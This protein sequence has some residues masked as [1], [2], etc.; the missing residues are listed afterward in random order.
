MP[1]EVAGTVPSGSVPALAGQTITAQT[2]YPF[3]GVIAVSGFDASS[4]TK[5]E[6]VVKASPSDPDSAAKLTIQLSNPGSGS[7][8]L[9]LLNGAA[10]VAPVVAA[11]GSITVGTANSSGL[12]ITVSTT[13]R[14]MGVAAGRYTWEL[15]VFLGGSKA[16]WLGSGQFVVDQTAY[17]VTS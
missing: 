10:P 17:A 16:P 11:D 4:W 12:S 5:L 8:G 3:S 15:V 1:N 13:A 2:N 9:T 7:D 6:F 14:G